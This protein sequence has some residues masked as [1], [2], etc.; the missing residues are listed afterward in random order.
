[1]Q[2]TDCGA[3]TRD[4][5]LSSSSKRPTLLPTE[6]N[7]YNKKFVLLHQVLF[8]EEPNC[9]RPAGIEHAYLHWKCSILPLNYERSDTHN[10]E[11]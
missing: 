8:A 5:G 3:R 6:L 4:I 2:D 10:N 7:R 9:L 1:M 11:L